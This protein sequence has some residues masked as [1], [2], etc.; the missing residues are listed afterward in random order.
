MLWEVVHFLGEVPREASTDSSGSGADSGNGQ[1]AAPLYLAVAVQH[2]HD[3]VVLRRRLNLTV[4]TKRPRVCFF[5][6]FVVMP[7]EGMTA[8]VC[9]IKVGGVRPLFPKSKIVM[10]P[11]QKWKP[12][13][14]LHCAQKVSTASCQTR[15][16]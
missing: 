6:L 7:C 8:V 15:P 2:M 3:M 10:H 13:I 14:S 4:C 5:D 12:Q 16:A 11:G 1:K 9:R